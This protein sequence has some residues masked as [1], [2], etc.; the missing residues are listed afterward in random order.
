[1]SY[2]RAAQDGCPWTHAAAQ[3]LKGEEGIVVP[4]VFILLPSD[5]ADC[6]QLTPCAARDDAGLG[7]LLA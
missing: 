5:A 4:A 3:R 2:V 1:M 7:G 6:E